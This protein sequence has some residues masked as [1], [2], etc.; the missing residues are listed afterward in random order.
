MTQKI[1]QKSRIPD[2]TSREEEAHFWDTHDF[3]DYWN[4]FKPVKIK[5]AK[6]LSGGITVR[7]APKVLT[8]IKN[9]A[10]QKGIGPTTLIRMW[11]MERLA[12]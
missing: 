3:T 4:E 2:F 12:G 9:K 11:V 7:F 8:E 10:A 5:F 6:N 1:K